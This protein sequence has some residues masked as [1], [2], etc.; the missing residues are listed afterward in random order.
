MIAFTFSEDD[1]IYRG[2]LIGMPESPSA[3]VDGN[4]SPRHKKPRQIPPGE[5]EAGASATE[6]DGYNDLPS[7]YAHTHPRCNPGAAPL[8]RESDFTLHWH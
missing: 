1:G 4:A 7:V 2:E 3:N 8:A 6:E 5:G